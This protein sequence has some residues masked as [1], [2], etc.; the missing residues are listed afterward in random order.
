M[1]LDRRNNI[2]IGGSGSA[3]ISSGGILSDYTSVQIGSKSGGCENADECMYTCQVLCCISN[4]CEYAQIE[5]KDVGTDYYVYEEEGTKRICNMYKA[6]PGK[7]KKNKRR[8]YCQLTGISEQQKAVYCPDFAQMNATDFAVLYNL[9][10]IPDDQPCPEQPEQPTKKRSLAPSYITEVKNEASLAE[11]FP[12]GITITV[13]GE[14]VT[15]YPGRGLTGILESC[16]QEGNLETV[17]NCVSSSEIPPSSYAYL[18]L[19]LN[20][21]EPEPGCCED[22]DTNTSSL[23]SCL[24]LQDFL[25][26]TPVPVFLNDK[27]QLFVIIADPNQQRTALEVAQLLADDVNEDFCLSSKLFFPHS[28][29]RRT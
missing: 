22:D 24:P 14:S 15:V 20:E 16:V 26:P 11:L 29:A 8:A 18:R 21:D 1:G 19:T 12:T 27:N 7:D 28:V 13:N 4:D 2:V 5:K 25:V 3:S 23:L 9:G 10:K 17:V 6:S